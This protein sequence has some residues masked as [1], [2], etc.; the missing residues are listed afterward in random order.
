MK[1]YYYLLPLLIIA[2]WLTA[3]R[4]AGAENIT[5]TT[6]YPSPSGAYDRLRLVPRAQLTG[7]CDTGF[8]YYW[9]GNNIRV[10][11][12]SNVWVPLS[13]WAQN[14]DNVYLSDTESNQNLKVGIGTKI[15]PFRLSLD[16]NG[17]PSPDGGIWAKGTYG[18]GTALGNPGAG[19]RLLWYPAKAAFRAGTVSGTQWDDLSIGN[20]SVAF[21]LDSVAS[22]DNS[23]AMGSGATASGTA[24]TALGIN[25]TASSY[26]MTAVGRYNISTGDSGG[27]VGDDPLFVVG[28]GTNLI[29]ANALTI[30]KS[31]NV[32]I[33]QSIP[34]ADLDINSAMR[35]DPQGSPPLTCGDPDTS[36]VLYVH[37]ALDTALCFCDGNSWQVA[38]GG[39]SCPP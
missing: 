8:L 17:N 4:P 37:S 30:L 29:P 1:K 33:N 9:D 34:K 19:T 2:A 28:N 7:S 23:M 13:P 22:G 6:Y 20:Y 18:S 36:G 24:S 10:C 14:G 21:G 35:L 38:A 3:A 5:L 12:N 27:W 32:G 11:D 31:G 26:A 25:T 16:I 15:P 39:G